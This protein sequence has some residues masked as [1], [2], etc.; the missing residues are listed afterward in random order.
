MLGFVQLR[1]VKNIT[2]FK[3]EVN[4]ILLSQFNFFVLYS[5]NRYFLLK[6]IKSL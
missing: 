5:H 6:Q 4:R 2:H 1:K 3:E